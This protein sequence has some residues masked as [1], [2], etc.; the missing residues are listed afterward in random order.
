MDA[1]A[2]NRRRGHVA[3]GD[4]GEDLPAV[5]HVTH[6]KAGSTWLSR[7]L[8]RC[9]RARIVRS[10]QGVAHVLD[11]PIEPGGVYPRV[12]LTREE[13]E[14]V[15]LPASWRRFVVIRDLRDTLV[16]AYFSTKFSHRQNPEN[17]FLSEDR[18]RLQTM[19]AKEGLSWMLD[20][21][22]VTKSA[23]I[24]DS[25]TRA[26][27][28]LIRYEDLV[29]HDIRILK[30]V[31]I[32]ECEFSLSPHQVRRIVRD[33]RFERLSGG[34]TRGDEEITS[35]FRKGVPGDWRNY[36][37]GPLKKAFKERWGQLLITTGY[38]NGIDW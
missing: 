5:F 22:V 26:E 23:K 3:P 36:F 28:P 20:Q 14:S 16:S 2:D 1:I 30:R 18:E 35:H 19:G 38:E 15:S 12:Y 29:E 37:T 17:P 8:G 32:D 24:Q 34:R 25:W 27:V 31:L 10:R 11:D 13:F 21:P 7:I 6:W 33:S 4:Q 9:D